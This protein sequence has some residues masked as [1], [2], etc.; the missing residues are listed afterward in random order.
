MRELAIPGESASPVAGPGLAENG[1]EVA[2]EQRQRVLKAAWEAMLIEGLGESGLGETA[3]EANV[4]KKGAGTVPTKESE[5]RGQDGKSSHTDFTTTIRQAM[6]KLKESEAGLKSESGST[7]EAD[8]LAKMLEQLGGQGEGGEEDEAELQGFLEGMMS[9]LMS[10]D[11]LYEPLKELSQK[12]PA[13]LASPPSTVTTADLERYKSQ[14]IIV[15]KI[16]AV[17]E[18]PGYRDDSEG[19]EADGEHSHKVMQL[20]G[21]MQALGSPPSEIMGDLPPGLG[22][23]PDGMPDPEGCSVM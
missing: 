21:E 17:F 6:E 19:G 1:G 13:Y 18:E 22:L 9:Q 10:K 8:A 7:S 23:G 12:F 15:N 2:E 14:Q 16:L 3:G 5:G 11:I 4:A 20:M